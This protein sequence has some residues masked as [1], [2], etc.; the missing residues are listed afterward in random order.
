MH[1]ITN[2]E[3]DEMYVN[4]NNDEGPKSLCNSQEQALKT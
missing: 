1:S 4:R 3:E 2:Q